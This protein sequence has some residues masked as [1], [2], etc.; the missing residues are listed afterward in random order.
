MGLDEILHQYV[1]PHEQD[2][3]MENLHVEIAGEHYGGC[4]T[5]KKILCFGLWWSIMHSDVTDYAKSCYGCQRTGKPSRW[6]E[7]PLVP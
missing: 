1:L 2:R 4:E 6:D 5:A 3:I 7:M